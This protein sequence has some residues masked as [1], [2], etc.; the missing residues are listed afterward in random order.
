LL[1]WIEALELFSYLF[2][3]WLFLFSSRFRAHVRLSWRKRRGHS[4]LLIPL[5]ITVAT[6]CGLL[7]LVLLW[8][9][10]R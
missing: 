3:F 8:W 2:G 5:E 4:R 10:L 1:E 6:I 9:A 7:P